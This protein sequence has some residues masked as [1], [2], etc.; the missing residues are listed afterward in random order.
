VKGMRAPQVAKRPI[1]S[2]SPQ[3]ARDARAR[4]WRFV[5]D[6]YA[7]KNPAA[8]PS[9]RGDNDGKAR[10]IPPMAT[11]YSTEPSPRDSRGILPMLR[12]LFSKHPEYLHHEAYELQ[13]LLWSLRY[14]DELL[15]EDEIAA[16][17]EVARADYDPDQGAA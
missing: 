10:R 15:D 9:V 2:I 8:G 14:T 6:A 12:D 16:A 1:D 7:R 5:L 17:A 13:Y 3:Q 4:A 11:F